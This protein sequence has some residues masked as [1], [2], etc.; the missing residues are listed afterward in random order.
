MREYKLRVMRCEAG[1]RAGRGANGAR[2]A[3]HG[4]ALRL[5]ATHYAVAAAGRAPTEYRTHCSIAVGER[6]YQMLRYKSRQSNIF[7]IT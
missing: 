1:G 2:R 3:G 5:V 7:H 6:A 4:P